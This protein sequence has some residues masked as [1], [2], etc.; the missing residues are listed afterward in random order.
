MKRNI[1]RILLLALVLLALVA[2]RVRSE[3]K[4][5]AQAVDEP[6]QDAAVMAVSGAEKELKL[7]KVV[8]NTARGGIDLTITAEDGTPTTYTFTDVEPDAWYT[9]AVNF[10]VSAGLMNGVAEKELFQPEYGV[11]RELFAV[12]IYRLADG[13]ASDTVARFEDVEA[14]RWYSDAVNWTVGQGLLAG[15]SEKEF[16]IGDF[17]TCE[18][19]LIVLHRLAGEPK[20]DATLENYPYAPK[21]SAYGADAVKWAWGTGLITEKECVWYPTQAISRAQV[22]LLLMRYS[23]MER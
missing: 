15:K 2:L 10:A 4:A 1:R 13:G 16:G 22:A 5:D 18:Q 6:G 20:S 11:T 12:I 19:A 23:A 14:D 8:A 17:V 7:G 3:K 21:V 9:R